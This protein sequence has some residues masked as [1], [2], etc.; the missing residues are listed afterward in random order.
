VCVRR[1]AE[2]DTRQ[3][4]LNLAFTC[5]KEL[6]RSAPLSPA[7]VGLAVETL[8]RL[9]LI[10]Y[11]DPKIGTPLLAPFHQPSLVWKSF[12][13]PRALPLIQEAPAVWGLCSLMASAAIRSHKLGTTAHWSR[14]SLV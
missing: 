8:H 7:A 1:I 14:P 12:V 9:C 3:G 2:A 11:V 5:I 10:R 13:E 4:H 6:F